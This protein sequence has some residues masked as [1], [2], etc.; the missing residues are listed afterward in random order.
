MPFSVCFSQF[1]VYREVFYGFLCFLILAL[2]GEEIIV[3]RV[4]LGIVFGF[5]LLSSF[6]MF[7][8]FEFAVADSDGFVLLEGNNV[9]L[10]MPEN[11]SGLN[12]ID[13]LT[14]FEAAKACDIGYDLL[15]QTVGAVPFS[16]DKIT[17]TAE[18]YDGEENFPGYAGHAG[19][20]IVV[21]YDRLSQNNYILSYSPED[22]SNSL[23]NFGL[24]FHEMYHNFQPSEF[25]DL[26]PR[27]HYG[28]GFAIFMANFIKTLVIYE[29]QNYN[30]NQSKKL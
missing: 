4:V 15:N 11:S 8:S 26:L 21:V 18:G 28:E 25:G 2:K 9:D 3:R 10:Y 23:P 1:E 6:L 7:V 22:G 27:Y 19:N 24:Y 5:L 30:L 29:A 17:I 14:D 13:V 16:G 20:P 12:F